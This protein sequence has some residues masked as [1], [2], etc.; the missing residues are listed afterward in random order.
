MLFRSYAGARAVR[1][2]RKSLRSFTLW[3]VDMCVVECD[4]G[5]VGIVSRR[6]ASVWARGC[7]NLSSSYH[8]PSR[9]SLRMV[10]KILE[11]DFG[12]ESRSGFGC[13][14]R[15][16]FGSGAVGR[17][18]T[19]EKAGLASRRLVG[20]FR[21]GRIPGCRY[22]RSPIVCAVNISKRPREQFFARRT[23]PDRKSTRLNS[24]H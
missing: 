3:L 21:R 24:S 14:S 22:C 1:F 16:M 6:A 8:H 9:K 19:A 17:T 11:M 7:D 15:V 18:R 20:V 23:F 13:E 10:A 2:F 12:A 5:V 4:R